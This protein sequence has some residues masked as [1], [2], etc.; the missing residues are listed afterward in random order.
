MSLRLW[1]GEYLSGIGRGAGAVPASLLAAGLQMR[2]AV[3]ADLSR[4]QA[5]AP[6]TGL[7]L[8]YPLGPGVAV[9]PRDTARAREP[10]EGEAALD[11]L[12]REGADHDLVWLVAPESGGLLERL[13]R[14][15]G[16][17]RWIGCTPEAI[18]LAGSKRAT[19][20]RLAAQGVCTPLAF[21]GHASAWIVKPDDGAGST[22]SQRH[23]QRARAEA[24][25]AARAARGAPATLEPWVDGEALSLSLLCR[26]GAAPELLAINRQHIEI[27]AAGQLRD[28]GVSIARIALQDP[29]ADALRALAAAVARALPG[30]RGYVGVDLVW[31]RERG[32]VAIEVNPRVTCA[33]AGLSAALGRNLAAEI[34]SAHLEATHVAA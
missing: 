1:V 14:A 30:L 32:P 22:D 7:A 20:A 9:A 23:V 17:R 29:R 28:A 31:H 8:F 26:A 15:V 10:R 12:L 3:L 18:A 24:D 27:D 33:Y 4:W 21:E 19:L 13:A 25:L 34:V 2:D 6:R 11:F 5:A 16:P